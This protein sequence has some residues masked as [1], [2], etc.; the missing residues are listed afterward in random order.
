LPTDPNAITEILLNAARSV[1]AAVTWL[2]IRRALPVASAVE[3]S[4][5]MQAL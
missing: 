3:V 2:V 5:W 4:S 1:G